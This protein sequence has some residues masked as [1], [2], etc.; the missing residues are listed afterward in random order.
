MHRFYVDN[1]TGSGNEINITG[2]DVNHIKNVLRLKIGDAIT[3]SDGSGTDYICKIADIMPDRV[4]T[5]IEDVM[6]NAAEL[7]TKI[8]LFQGMPKS[9]KLEFIIQKAVEL[10]VAEIVPVITKRTVAKPDKKKQEK[11]LARYN[12][13]AESAAKQSGRGVI[14]VVKPFLSFGE[15][16]SHAKDLDMNLIPYEEAR[17]IAYSREVIES[18]RGKKSLGIFIGPEGGF[19]KE[20]IAAAMEMG[21][22]CITLGNRILR[23]ET[24]GLVVLSLIMFFL[25]E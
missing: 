14:P 12:A 2:S 8:T 5:A 11:K 15:A 13:I 19:A 17:G 3:V 24:A 23:T 4:V 21:A 20:E 25:E 9:D 16:L 22:H 1:F 10:G 18:I 7:G 6:G